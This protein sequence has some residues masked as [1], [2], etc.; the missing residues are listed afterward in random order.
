MKHEMDDAALLDGAQ[1]FGCDAEELNVVREE[2][3]GRREKQRE[4]AGKYQRES[5]ENQEGTPI[6]HEGLQQTSVIS[7]RLLHRERIEISYRS[8]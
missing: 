1:L 2:L 3:S 4:A 7:N 5:S 8:L 6:A